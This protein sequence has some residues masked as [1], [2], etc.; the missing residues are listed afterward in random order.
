MAAR[1]ALVSKIELVRT[2]AAVLAAGLRIGRVEV[3]HR[4]GKVTVYSEGIDTLATANPCDRLLI[5]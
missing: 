2:L 4:T 3:D 1:P 5:K